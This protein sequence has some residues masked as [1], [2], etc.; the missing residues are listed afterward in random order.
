MVSH[1]V[2]E[3]HLF[4]GGLATAALVAPL[5]QPTADKGT[6]IA[7][8]NS[9]TKQ[10]HGREGYAGCHNFVPLRLC[11]IHHAYAYLQTTIATCEQELKQS[12][13]P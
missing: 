8:L 4:I 2:F 10:H 5:C 7:Q 9:S 12:L 1:Q 13:K 6:K 11:F 3:T